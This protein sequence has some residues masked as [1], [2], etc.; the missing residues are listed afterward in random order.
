MPRFADPGLLVLTSLLDGPKHGYALISDIEQMCGVRLGPG[1]LY[2][3]LSA[4]EERGHIR[5]LPAHGRRHPYEL[6][7]QGRQVVAD[8]VSVWRGVVRT[9]VTRLGLA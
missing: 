3:S 6:T 9:A 8:Q 2:G 4:L 7:D 5:A 1:T